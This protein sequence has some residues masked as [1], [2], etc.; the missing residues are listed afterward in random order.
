MRSTKKSN[1]YRAIILWLL[2]GNTRRMVGKKSRTDMLE[3]LTDSQKELMLQVKEEWI[4]F[5]LGGNTEVN[6]Q[7]AAEGIRWIYGLAKLK[8]PFVIFVNG[9]MECQFAIWFLK[10]MLKNGTPDQVWDQVGD[11]VWD[12][13][14]DQVRA[15]VGDQVWD[16]VWAQ[17][18]DQ[19]SDLVSDQF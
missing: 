9:P 7:I 8:S 19:V 10:A 4:N 3:K 2:K 5:C 1:L 18:C 16:Q 15:Q 12:Q 13:V 11:Q 14:G 17:V 6:R